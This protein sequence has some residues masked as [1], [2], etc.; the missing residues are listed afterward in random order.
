L[1]WLSASNITSL[2]AEHSAKAKDQMI[3]TEAGI[4]IHHSD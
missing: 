3:S 1:S 4:A 2:S